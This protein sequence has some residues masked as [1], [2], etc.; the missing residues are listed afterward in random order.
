MQDILFKAGLFTGKAL[1]LQ[2]FPN[3]HSWFIPFCQE[4]LTTNHLPFLHYH[5]SKPF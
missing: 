5:F 1:F 2:M 4:Y 3:G